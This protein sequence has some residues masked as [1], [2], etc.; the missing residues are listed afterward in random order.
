M[1]FATGGLQGF[2]IRMSLPPPQFPI[3]V[4]VPTA[5]IP[6]QVPNPTPVSSSS[7]PKKEDK[8]I[9]K[10]KPKD[11]PHKVKRS[12]RFISPV[13]RRVEPTPAP[14]RTPSPPLDSP[15]GASGIHRSRSRSPLDLSTNPRGDLH[16]NSEEEEEEYDE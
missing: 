16:D 9:K 12:H 1:L 2:P 3:F 10:R 6:S 11:L 8:K 15:A 14:P 13:R 5:P 4:P 7:L